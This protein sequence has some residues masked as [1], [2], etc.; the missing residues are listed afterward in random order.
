MSHA[1]IY[2]IENIITHNLYIGKAK[3]IEHRWSHH[4]SIAKNDI[5]NKRHLYNSIRQYGIENFTFEIIEEVPLNIYDKV[6]NEKEK[7]WI[8]YYNAYEDKDNYNYTEGGDGL[9]GWTPSE[10]WKTKQSKIKKEWY[11][12]ADGKKFKEELSDRM[13]N[14]ESLFKGHIHTEE[15]KHQHSLD[16]QGDKN[17]NYQKHGRGK[18][19][20]CIELNKIFESTRQ[21]EQELGI[22]HQNIASACRGIYQTSGGY[23]WK[24][25]ED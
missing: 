9:S 20:F 15:W 25:I 22:K 10:E 23:H 13:K 6:I 21:A 2:K 24:Y 19:C 16:M 7:Y 8:K 4:K 11:K 1:G 5:E 12:T 14:Q 3:N 17:P 18:K